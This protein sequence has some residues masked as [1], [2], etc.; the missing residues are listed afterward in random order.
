MKKFPFRRRPRGP[1]GVLAYVALGSNL[2]DRAGTL[3]WALDR[4]HTQGVR[5]QQSSSFFMRGPTLPN[6]SIAA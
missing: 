5:V 3:Q 4:M 2:G 1:E 6:T